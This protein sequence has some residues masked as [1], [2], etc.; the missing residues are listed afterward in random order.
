VLLLAL[1]S[2]SACDNAQEEDL[3]KKNQA[4]SH[5]VEQLKQE[6]SDLEKK[7]AELQETDQ[8]YWSRAQEERT[9]G[10]WQEASTLAEKLVSR[11]PM[12]P[13]ASKAKE[14]RSE[15]RSEEANSLLRQAD[16]NLEAGNTA[17]ISILQELVNK[18]PDLPAGKSV[19]S[20]IKTAE[21]ELKQ[22]S[23]GVGKWSVR[24]EVSPIDDST[25]V[26]LSL[27]AN[28]AVSSKLKT[29]TPTLTLRCK[30][31]KTEAFINWGVYLG[32]DETN[33]L[34]RLDGGKASQSS[35]SISTDYEATFV[36]G[37][38]GF[39]KRMMGHEKMLARV[40]PYSE[41]S[42]TV[43]FDIAGLSEAVKPL[44]KA[45]KWN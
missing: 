27:E 18:Y 33:V 1:G 30:E 44:Q 10:N 15:A 12:S 45:C 3:K 34:V 8:S 13:L 14:L 24:T 31:K 35:W 42:A 19:A 29:A 2:L 17:A 7:I 41:S 25:N 36:P 11:W 37:G 38:A 23:I 16:K 22:K 39:I 40:T 26:Y 5:E 9:K 32:I 4:L 43:T 6:K 21:Q 20:K 28:E